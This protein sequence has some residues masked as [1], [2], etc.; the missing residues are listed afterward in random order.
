MT[1]EKK[2]VLTRLRHPLVGVTVSAAILA[3]L[4]TALPFAE[5]RDAV[6][7]V[8]GSA[9]AMA[10]PAYLLLHLLGVTKW[11]TVVNAA[12]AGL[13]LRGAAAAYY[14]GLFGSTFLPS[15]VGGDVVRA[16]VAFRHVRSRGALV[17]GS[18]VDRLLDVIGLAAV[19]GIGALLSPRA[20]D[21]DS[22][23]VFV[24]L[25]LLLGGGAVIAGVVTVMTPVRK[26]PWK[27]RRLLVKVRTAVRATAARPLLLARAFIGGMVLQTGLTALNWWLGLAMGLD[28][29]FYVWLFVWPLAKIA[30]LLPLTQNGIG[31][32]EAA[33]V[34]LCAP[35]GIAAPQAVAASLVFQVV[36]LAGGLAG[37][38]ISWILGRGRPA[39]QPG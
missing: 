39:I 25:G 13:P 32:R 38:A 23:R 12:D 24:L 6:A 36:V 27:I 21:D 18:L 19:A 16:G 10:L 7:R 35:F 28:V 29:P 9:W 20:L 11:R 4:F 14:M 30:A 33:F 3:L 17:L 8:P 34:A 2:R 15:I 37:G 1:R 26:F 31:V 22:R 5:I